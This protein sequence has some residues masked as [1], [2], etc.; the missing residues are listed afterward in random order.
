M[1]EQSVAFAEQISLAEK[2]FRRAYH[3]A[4]EAILTTTCCTM[5]AQ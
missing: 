3:S 2:R 5:S 1:H 4:V